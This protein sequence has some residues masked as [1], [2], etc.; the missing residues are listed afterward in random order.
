[1]WLKRIS[2]STAA[3]AVAAAGVLVPPGSSTAAPAD[4]AAKYQVT[5]TI[6]TSWPRLARTRSR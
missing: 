4:E 1:M 6:S 2:I 5:L 3:L